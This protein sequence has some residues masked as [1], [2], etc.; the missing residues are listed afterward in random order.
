MP[1][2]AAMISLL[3]RVVTSNRKERR[4][5][6]LLDLAVE[7]GCDPEVQEANGCR[8]LIVPAK[9]EGKIVALT[10]HYDVFGE[11]WGWNDNG[12]GLAVLLSLLNDVPPHVKFV[13]TDNEESNAVLR[14]DGFWV[15]TDLAL[16]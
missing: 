11:S 2:D 15:P 5:A 8:N 16:I 12:S 9:T 4:F 7:A 6:N 1:D 13:F 10:A 3:K 14:H